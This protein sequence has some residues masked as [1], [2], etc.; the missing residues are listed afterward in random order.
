MAAITEKNEVSPCLVEFTVQV[1]KETVDKTLR[2]AYRELAEYTKIPG[3]RKG[4]APMELLIRYIDEE[5]AKNHAR[6]D[7][8]EKAILEALIESGVEE[9][10][11]PPKCSDEEYGEDGSFTFKAS[12][13]K[14]PVVELGKYT[15]LT[16][17]KI[18]VEVT[19]EQIDGR[20]NDLR[21][22]RC[23]YK[24]VDP[25]PLRDGDYASIEIM[26]ESL[27]S[28]PRRTRIQIG[29]NLADFDEGLKGMTPG[30][31]K[32]ITITF[33]PE[34]QH[35]GQTDRVFVKVLDVEEKV[36][37][38]LDDEFAKKLGDFDNMDAVRAA[39]RESLKKTGEESAKRDLEEQLIK[40]IVENS[41][42][43][44]PPVMKENRVRDKL[45]DILKNLSE[46]GLSLGDFLDNTGQTFEELTAKLEEDAERELKVGLILSEIAKKE[47]IKVEDADVDAEIEQLAEQQGLPA[48][49]MRAM[50]DA[51]DEMEKLR[52]RI[53][54][55]KILDFLVQAS[56]IQ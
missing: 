8:I 23:E 38:N 51:N 3:F 47:Q 45:Q 15:G 1:E 43:H 41:K 28:E 22:L 36:L 4:K 39:I 20:I 37:P 26:Q 32:T 42:I 5:R 52:N 54:Q 14:P 35:D 30:E 34:H 53:F 33:P 18:N 29:S 44:F 56:N 17:K 50:I 11:G 6:E 31:E 16:A 7:I 12:V 48:E 9:I 55:Q 25:R 19:D 21:E 10:Y 40:Q 27:D 46:R 13:S 2:K 24:A 49:S